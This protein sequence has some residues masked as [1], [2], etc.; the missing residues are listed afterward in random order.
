MRTCTSTRTG[1][2]PV[3]HASLVTKGARKVRGKNLGFFGLRVSHV[4]RAHLN[5]VARGGRSARASGAHLS[6]VSVGESRVARCGASSSNLLCNSKRKN[7]AALIA[8]H[9]WQRFRGQPPNRART[10]L[11]DIVLV[12][13]T[14]KISLQKSKGCDWLI[15]ASASIRQAGVHGGLAEAIAFANATR[16]R[17]GETAQ[18]T[19][20]WRQNQRKP[21]RLA[22]TGLLPWRAANVARR[23]PMK[24]PFRWKSCRIAER[25][26][27]HGPRRAAL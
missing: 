17:I 10:A 15:E 2:H 16:Y 27:L 1:L 24:C 18:W 3:S 9:A 4:P 25:R 22:T 23:R 20:R 19:A 11:A 12:C 14:L 26:G 7:R 21:A 13:R 8:H 5:G 6:R